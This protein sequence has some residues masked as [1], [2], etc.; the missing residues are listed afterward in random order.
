MGFL[1]G[2]NRAPAIQAPTSA[3]GA[4][5]NAAGSTAGQLAAPSVVSGDDALAKLTAIRAALAQTPQSQAVQAPPSLAG[6]GLR[7]TYQPTAPSYSPSGGGS[8]APSG[9]ASA[10]PGGPINNAADFAAAVLSGL[11]DRQTAANM[12]SMENWEAREGG[13]WNNT[14]AFN[15][16]NT[17]LVYDGSH[18]MNGGNSAGVQA[19]KNWADGLAATI[20]TLRNGNYGDILNALASGQGLGGYLS[21]L[22]TWSGGGYYSV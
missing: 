14:A 20:Q 12:R 2:L 17:T 7:D 6:A 13:N 4:A 8:S 10:T 1:S 11:G 15:P 18:V 5:A 3:A 9:L 22:G 21:G 19:Y 16:L